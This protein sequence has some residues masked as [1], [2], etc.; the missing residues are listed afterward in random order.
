MLNNYKP[1]LTAVAG[2]SDFFKKPFA[3]AGG[4]LFYELSGIAIIF[5]LTIVC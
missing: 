5:A 2:N 3:K 4:F 1:K